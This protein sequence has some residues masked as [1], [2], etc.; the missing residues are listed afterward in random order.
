[1]R[2]LDASR[3]RFMDGKLVQP[4]HPFTADSEQAV[5]PLQ[6]FRADV[7]VFPTSAVIEAGHRLR[8]SVGASDLPHGLSSIPDLLTSLLG[9][10]TIYSTPGMP[11]RV[12]I[13]LVPIS[14]LNQ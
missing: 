9:T 4:W 13:P 2:A 3:S 8:I 5:T 14:A 6:P 11:S 1:M 10:L 12:N 7:E